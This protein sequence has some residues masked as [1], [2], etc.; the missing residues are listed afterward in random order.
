MAS[1]LEALEKA[2]ERNRQR[3]VMNT[4]RQMPV[5]PIIPTGEVQ[6]I[7]LNTG[8]GDGPNI[9]DNRTEMEKYNDLV[10]ANQLVPNLPV[11]GTGLGLLNDYQINK[12]EEENPALRPENPF[13]KKARERFSYAG[14]VLNA[15]GYP[16]QGGKTHTTIWDRITGV[17]PTWAE[18]LARIDHPVPT[19]RRNYNLGGKSFI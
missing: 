11:I 5:L 4:E 7:Q 12:M 9:Q 2:Q 6:P 3:D 19:N 18:S 16:T 17:D 10:S 14:R 15:Y 8:G 13:S 1:I